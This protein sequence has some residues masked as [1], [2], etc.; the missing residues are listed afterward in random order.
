MNAR[1]LHIGVLDIQ[2]QVHAVSFQEGV[3]VVTGRSSTG[4]SALIEIFDF[5]FGS[6][7]FTVPVGVI[8]DCADLYFTVMKVNESA[9]VLARRSRDTRAFLKEELDLQRL[10]QV[11]TL[12]VDYFDDDY[13]SPISD[14]LKELKRYFG[15][16]V[17][18]IDEDLAARGWRGAKSSTPSARSF[19][20]FMLQHQNLVANKHAI[21]YRFDQKV[22]R[23]QAI[24]HLKI[25]L[26]FADQNYFI[27]SQELNALLQ[28][29]RILERSLPRREGAKESAKIKLINALREYEA[30]SGKTLIDDLENAVTH[31]KLTLRTLREAKI[32]VVADSDA[33]A[34]LRQEAENEERKLV[35]RLRLKQ[36]E[37]G[38]V[39]SSIDFSRR[40]YERSNETDVPASAELHVSICPFCNS[41]NNNVEEQANELTDAINWLNSELSRSS[42]RLESFEEQRKKVQLD[43]DVIKPEL[44]LCRQQI[45]AIDK[46]ITD[47]EKVRSQYELAVESKIR[48][49]NVLA[50][51][52]DLQGKQPAGDLEKLRDTIRELK[53]YL[54]ANYNIESNLA[55]AQLRIQELLTLFG[56]RFDFEQ[57][58][59]PIKLNFDLET[60]DLWHEMGADKKVFLRSMGSGA[61]WLS[62]HL[63]LFLALQRYFCEVGKDCTIPPILF[64][65]QPSQVYFPS[66]LD[67]GVEFSAEELAKKDTSRDKSRPVDEDV[68]AVTNLFDQLV[69]Y[70]QETEDATGIMPQIIVTDHADHLILSGAVKFESLIRARWRQDR[71]GFIELKKIDH[72]S[73]IELEFSDPPEATIKTELLEEES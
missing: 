67:G 50:E 22:K 73:Q 38:S 2:G 35:A 8:T 72:G 44:A 24:E 52:A 43:I 42:Y 15:V 61:N 28:E 3:N 70:C 45:K 65:D 19:T 33:H 13:F 53:S 68:K 59:T 54:K 46:Q 1:I 30:I 12:S 37:L 34:R 56:N 20:S 5:C 18:D 4:K 60:F 49:E 62:C 36:Q 39:I 10:E 25:F 47:L 55:K 48:V 6:S 31:P 9:L 63:V 71:D 27:K 40:H 57:S 58:Y 11:D 14:F 21:F 41:Q 64:F 66:I 32:E 23:E 69:T 51:L 16:V 26:G 7:N 17:T 29:Q